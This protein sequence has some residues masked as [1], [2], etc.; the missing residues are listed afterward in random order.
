MRVHCKIEQD[1]NLVGGDKVADEQKDAHDDVLGNGD[2]V[3]AGDLENLDALLDGR[4]QI[5]VVGTD[6]S[7]D[8]DLEVLRLRTIVIL[9]DRESNK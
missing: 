8:T 6:T 1:T 7:R 3:R 9:S 4:V 5:D 2:D